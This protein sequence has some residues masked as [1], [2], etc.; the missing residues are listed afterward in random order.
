MG[1]S[2]A[3]LPETDMLISRSDGLDQRLGWAVNL[4]EEAL[5]YGKGI[6]VMFLWGYQLV[7]AGIH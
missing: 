7:N 2:T 3:A 4:I 6:H 1:I 5:Q